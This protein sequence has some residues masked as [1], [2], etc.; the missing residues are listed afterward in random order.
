MVLGVV[1]TGLVKLSVCLL[2]WR[3]FARVMF[4]RFL[5]AWIVVIV[6]WTVAFTLAGL[7]E[8]GSHLT[9]LFSSPQAYYEFCGAAVPA[10]YGMI[11]SDLAT[12]L[13]TL[14]IPIPVI[15]TL[16]MD[17]KTKALTLLTFSVGAM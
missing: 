1:A 6:C 17:A 16:V 8:C 4:R 14:V 3:L 5:T 10:G 13:V 12:D 2:Y 9:A 15:M 11:A 7:L